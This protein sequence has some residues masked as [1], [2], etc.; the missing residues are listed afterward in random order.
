[1]YSVTDWVPISDSKGSHRTNIV[2]W[3]A[4]AWPYLF[5]SCWKVMVC[6][7]TSNSWL[8]HKYTYSSVPEWEEYTYHRKEIKDSW[9][10]DSFVDRCSSVPGWERRVQYTFRQRWKLLDVDRCWCYLTCVEMR[11][12]KVMLLMNKS[13]HV[14]CFH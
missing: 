8:M 2:G 9:K 11:T 6:A 10:I 3:G 1:L 5:Y 7:R 4:R 14:F 13:V 12:L